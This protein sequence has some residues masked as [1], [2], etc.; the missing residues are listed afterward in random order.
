MA[1]IKTIYGED[2]RL[3]ELEDR[4]VATLQAQV[5]S[6]YGLA[7]TV[8]LKYQYQEDWITCATD[9]ELL[10]GLRLTD[11]PLNVLV[12]HV[13]AAAD[14]AAMADGVGEPPAIA[15]EL[16]EGEMSD[17]PMA[18]SY[19]AGETNSSGAV[20]PNPFNDAAARCREQLGINVAGGEL[21]AIVRTLR[22]PP[23]RLVKAGLIER[24]ERHAVRQL[25]CP[26]GVEAQ[27]IH[28]AE[29]VDEHDDEDDDEDEDEDEDD[30]DDNAGCNADVGE[31]KEACTSS[32]TTATAAGTGRGPIAMAMATFGASNISEPDLHALLRLLRVRAPGKRLVKAGIVQ[33][34]ELSTLRADS[35]RW[36]RETKDRV[37]SFKK[38]L[39]RSGRGAH[40]GG[41]GRRHG[42]HHHHHRSGHE[43]HWH[44]PHHHFGHGPPPPPRG[45]F[46]VGPGH[47]GHGPPPPPPHHFDHH[48]FHPQHGH[49]QPFFGARPGHEH[50]PH[51]HPR[52]GGPRGFHFGGPRGPP[53]HPEFHGHPGR[54]GGMASFGAARGGFGRGGPGPGVAP[55]MWQQQQQQ[56]QQQQR[57]QRWLARFVRHVTL[58]D[59]TN[60]APSSSAVKTW[61]V[62]NDGDCAWP[63]HVE[64]ILVADGGGGVQCPSR[65]VVRGGVA[66]G[67]EADISVRI[68]AP[69][70]AGQYQSYWR[71]CV[72][73][74]GA[75]A[76]ESEQSGGRKF[77]QRL[78]LNVVVVGSGDTS[79]SDEGFELVEGDGS[80]S[81]GAIRARLMQRYRGNVER[82]EA[83]LHKLKLGEKS[84]SPKK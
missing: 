21:L 41:G 50:T 38:V 40:G 4:T 74:T 9:Q 68:T 19:H 75:N 83:K 58:P 39:R 80:V 3:F 42:R 45:G 82:V 61:R 26:N 76:I 69:A 30:D 34:S 84:E 53:P 33:G 15:V 2:T 1:L 12:L 77:G 57:K 64:L 6:L 8:T 60:L 14:G 43:R 79:N 17:V 31:A 13:S 11:P 47:H 32:T 51:A 54:G 35:K 49:G 28:E 46:G 18:L 63:D 16:A 44:H 62:R 81:P 48:G 72:A 67:E 20:Q 59:G 73:E 70:A 55:D 23:W 10:L 22:L 25:L 29:L 78:W 52:P 36:K 24:H 71:L 65:T 37:K 5:A 27:G 56:Q 7:D 66:P